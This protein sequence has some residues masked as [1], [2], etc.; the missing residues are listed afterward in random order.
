MGSKS[1]KTRSSS[2]STTRTTSSST[3]QTSS[4]SSGP[5]LAE[6]DL[7]TGSC[8]RTCVCVCACS[9]TCIKKISLSSDKN[10]V[11]SV[12][13]DTVF[14]LELQHERVGLGG[15]KRDGRAALLVDSCVDGLQ[16]HGRG[17]AE[18]RVD[19]LPEGPDVVVRN[20]AH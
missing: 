5:A 3:L 11:V 18:Q 17:L 9:L 10:D 15:S 1:T 19:R 16:R 12:D 7:L 4:V 6:E 14:V 13:H 8:L 20:G 2:T